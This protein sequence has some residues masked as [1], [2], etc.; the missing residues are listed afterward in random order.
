MS[1]I[2]KGPPERPSD[3]VTYFRMSDEWWDISFLCWARDPLLRPSLSELLPKVEKTKVSVLIHLY[4]M[5]TQSDEAIANTTQLL[6]QLS[7]RANYFCINL[8]DQVDRDTEI[9][10]LRDSNAIIC[11]GSLRPVGTK[12]TVKTVRAGLPAGDEQAIEVWT[13]HAG[14]HRSDS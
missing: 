7:Q 5:L 12:I 3:N 14:F 4:N 6:T 13:V 9:A 10:P 11:R 8:D 2:L 1:R